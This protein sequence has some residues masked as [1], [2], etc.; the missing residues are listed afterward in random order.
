MDSLVSTTRHRNGFPR[1][2]VILT[3]RHDA[4]SAAG[5]ATAFR[6][7]QPSVQLE[8]TLDLPPA[9]PTIGAEGIIWKR[10]RPNPTLEAKNGL[11]RLELEL[12]V[13]PQKIPPLLP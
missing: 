7:G 12:G 4:D 8:E 1:A 13:H 6:P 2:Q 5:H 11:L 3:V 10:G 9:N